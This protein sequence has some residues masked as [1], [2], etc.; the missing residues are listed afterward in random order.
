MSKNTIKEIT[1]VN[2]HS[3]KLYIGMFETSQGNIII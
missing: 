3:L 2:E 1:Q